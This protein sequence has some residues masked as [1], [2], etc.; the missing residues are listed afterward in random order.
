[1]LS[2]YQKRNC[3][4]ET[5]YTCTWLKCHEIL[6]V[7]HLETRHAYKQEGRVAFNGDTPTARDWLR[8]VMWLISSP[9]SVLLI[10]TE[11]FTGFS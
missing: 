5:K 4:E 9:L 8:N 1:M 6:V 2:H 3:I 11:R 10:V 7:F